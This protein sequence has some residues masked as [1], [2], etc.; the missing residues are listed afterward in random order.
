MK[1][2]LFLGATLLLCAPLA[3]TFVSVAQAQPA[4]SCGPTSGLCW[5]RLVRGEHGFQTKALQNLLNA[6]GV[7]L[8]A[9]GIFGAS[10]VKAVRA[11]QKKRKLKVDG[12]VGWQTWEKLVVDI[13]R[14]SRGRSVSTLQ[15]LLNTQDYEV[16]TDGFFGAQT[17]RAVRELQ[18]N[19]AITTPNGR[20][21]PTVWCSLLGGHID[22]E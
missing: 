1:N 8:K 20:A 16:A 10:T 11:F 9:D 19:I 18:E 14:G 6:R 4:D 2:S 17:E 3:P 12:L 21:T 13:G 5:P 22:G 7:A 15:T